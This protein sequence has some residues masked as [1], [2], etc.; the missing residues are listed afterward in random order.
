MDARTSPYKQ[1]Y[2]SLNLIRMGIN[3]F[4]WAQD[5]NLVAKTNYILFGCT[6]IN[7]DVNECDWFTDITISDVFE[8]MSIRNFFSNILLIILGCQQS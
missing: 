6:T 8:N 7:S 3:Q 4:E 2:F 1:K 5:S